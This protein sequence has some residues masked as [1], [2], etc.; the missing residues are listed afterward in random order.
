MRHRCR[1]DPNY[2]ER[3][4]TVCERWNDFTLFLEDMGEKPAG[5]SI[6][7]VVNDS[8][9]CPTN[10]V[11]ANRSTQNNNRRLPR[12]LKFIRGND[13]MRYIVKRGNSYCLSI[14]IR[15]GVRYNSS[16]LSLDEMLTERANCEM[17]RQMFHL[18]GGS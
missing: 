9:Y 2:V 6:E 18:L 16:S 13:P 11:W 17:E 15:K 7:R 14:C 3:G 12:F 10:C 1:R 4:I 5:L 8:H